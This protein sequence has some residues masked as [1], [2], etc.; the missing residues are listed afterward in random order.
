MLRV[1]LSWQWNFGNGNSSTSQIPA[2]QRYPVG[3][4]IEY[5]VSLTVVDTGGC[6]QTASTIINSVNNCYIAVPAAFTPNGDGLN[7][8]LYPLNA[9]KATNLSFKVFNRQG[10]LVYQTNNW[11]AKWDGKV[12]GEPQAP[13][14][15]VWILNYLDSDKK[16]VALKGTVM[17]LR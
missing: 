4:G 5:P 13:G 17:L 15:Y 2:A 1:L 10:M 7:D 12:H 3:N 11:L 6:M 8:Y 16:K 9:Y 14:T